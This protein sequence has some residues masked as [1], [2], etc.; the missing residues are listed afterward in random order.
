MIKIIIEQ[1]GDLVQPSQT[2][3]ELLDTLNQ[4]AP[5][6]VRLVRGNLGHN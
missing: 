6:F 1:A 2:V 4:H 3:Q 5:T